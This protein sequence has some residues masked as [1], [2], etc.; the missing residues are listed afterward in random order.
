MKNLISSKIKAFTLIEL[1][2]VIAIIGILITIVVPSVGG[3]MDKAKMVATLSNYKQLYNFSYNAN[4]DTSANT[5]GGFPG[6]CG[7]VAAWSNTLISA[8]CDAKTFQKLFVVNGQAANT[9]CWDGN[10]A[11]NNSGV[12]LSTKNITGT[13]NSATVQNVAPYNLKGGVVICVDG[14]G[15]QVN[16]T[17]VT[18][19]TNSAVFGS[20]VN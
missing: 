1:L 5:N 16:G 10:P 18:A 8:G 19:L 9:Q 3:A 13:S 17:N 15:Y 7:S 20:V 6:T 2:V 12:M 14:G 4:L 11:S